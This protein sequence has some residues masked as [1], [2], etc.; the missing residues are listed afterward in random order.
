MRSVG[1]NNTVRFIRSVISQWKKASAQKQFVRLMLASL[2]YI[3]GLVVFMRYFLPYVDQR[4]GRQLHNLWIEHLPAIDLSPVIFA[5]I[6][7]SLLLTLIYV[8]NKPHL[9]LR[10]LVTLAIMYTLRAISLYLVPLEPPAGC[11]PLV[12]PVITW[13]IDD[14]K[15]VVKD[16]FF[17][18]HT[19]CL[20]ICILVVRKRYA[21]IVLCCAL[22]AVIVML[23]FQHAHYFI[24]I[25]GAFL[26][27]PICWI[28]S[29]WI[30]SGLPGAIQERPA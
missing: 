19:A 15:V 20:F 23:L 11:I 12:D 25:A 6:Y 2:I 18:G 5:V 30:L 16:L 13:L 3:G 14:K 17:S 28:M 21:E 8:L 9:F 10:L 27:T 7:L 1:K 4:P 22:V 26:I 29:G 24:D